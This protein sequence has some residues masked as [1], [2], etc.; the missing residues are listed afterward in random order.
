ML[1][2]SHSVVS[3]SLQPYGLIVFQAPLSVEFSRQVYWS[4]LPFPSPDEEHISLGNM[5]IHFYEFYAGC[6]LVIEVAQNLWVEVPVK[7]VHSFTALFNTH[8]ELLIQFC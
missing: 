1:C 4:R 6:T 7:R 3:N 5:K 2:F 8:Y